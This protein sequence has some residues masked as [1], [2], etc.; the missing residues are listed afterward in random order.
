MFILEFRHNIYGFQ[1][2][3]EVYD[4]DDQLPIIMTVDEFQNFTNN[5]TRSILPVK[6]QIVSRQFKILI[7]MIRPIAIELFMGKNTS[8]KIE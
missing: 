4:T 8:Q 1:V 5:I 7:R 3:D 2:N 6:K